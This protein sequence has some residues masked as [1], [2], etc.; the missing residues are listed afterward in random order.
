[1]GVSN[2][3]KYT[4]IF[5]ARN[6]HKSLEVI[7]PFLINVS[8]HVGEILIVADSKDDTTFLLENRF[9]GSEIPVRFIL[10]HQPGVFGAVKSG[11]GES[12]NPFVIICAADEFIPLLQIDRFAEALDSGI[13][14]VSATRY[15][16]GGQRFGG[17]KIGRILSW[18]ANRVLNVFFLGKMTDFTTGIKGFSK[19]HWS[20]L[21][22]GARDGGWSFALRFSL[23][24]IKSEMRILEIPIISLDRAIG[25]QSTFKL[26]N[27]IVS[28]IKVLFHLP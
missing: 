24:A 21:Q 27:W 3:P 25:G 23:N 13:E 14:F 12:K 19:S 22:E 18:T 26:L 7:I 1:M 11:V 9:V 17:S 20:L 10:N 8:K 15:A 5:P 2:H 4:A 28:Y 6:E 16:N